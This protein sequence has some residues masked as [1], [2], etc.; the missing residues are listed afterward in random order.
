[1]YSSIQIIFEEK[2]YKISEKILFLLTND[3]TE[4]TPPTL[5]KISGSAH[6]TVPLKGQS[7]KILDLQFFSLF[8]PALATDG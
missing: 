3:R 7:S 1:M 2:F 8:E 5:I 6:K 4:N